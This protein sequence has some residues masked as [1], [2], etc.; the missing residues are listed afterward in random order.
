[1]NEPEKARRAFAKALKNGVDF[2]A[3]ERATVAA[4]LTAFE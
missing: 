3:A 4:R 2:R 1:L